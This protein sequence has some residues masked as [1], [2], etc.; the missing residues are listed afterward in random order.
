MVWGLA[1]VVGLVV[2]ELAFVLALRARIDRTEMDLA[3]GASG[4]TTYLLL[5]TDDRRFVRTEDER[6]L[7]GDPVAIPGARADVVMV[8]RVPDD[9]PPTV[10]LVSRDL[11]A[12]MS[13]GRTSRLSL[14]ALEGPGAVADAVCWSLGV[15]VDH[16][17]VLDLA[18]FQAVV[19]AVGGVEVHV[20]RPLRDPDLGLALDRPGV[21]HLD[22]QDALSFV[23]TRTAEVLVDGE[24]VPE[25]GGHELRQARASQVAAELAGADIPSIWHPIRSHRVLWTA[26]GAVSGSQSLGLGELGQIAG[27]LADEELE[28]VEV[29]VR[30]TG[31]EVPVA[32]LSPGAAATLAPHATDGCPGVAAAAGS[33]GAPTGGDA[34][35]PADSTATAPALDEGLG[36]EG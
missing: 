31:D 21:H 6:L 16:V 15:G 7:Y 29:P 14:L 17:A 10:V 35:L 33:V 12:T 36:A 30:T 9:G 4:G 13:D 27:A 26:T 24:W 34:P 23:R 11:M 8:L 5:G 32:D 25:G 1:I 22:G 3:G 19:D 20:D 28:V 2:V 18:G